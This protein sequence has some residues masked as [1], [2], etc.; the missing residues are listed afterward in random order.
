M[1]HR[2]I[3]STLCSLYEIYHIV[4]YDRHEYLQHFVADRNTRALAAPDELA[5]V[6]PLGRSDQFSRSFL[7]VTV[8]L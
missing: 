5:L 2:R 8:R 1:E 7:P 3:V 4:D 6:I